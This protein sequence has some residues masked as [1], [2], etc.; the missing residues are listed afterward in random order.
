VL[1]AKKE[2]LLKEDFSRQ[3]SS[4]LMYK[5]LHYLQD[6]ARTLRKPLFTGSIAKEIFGMALARDMGDLD[7]AAVYRIFNEY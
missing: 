7:L 1:N 2:Q 4:A 5:D 3:F 6:L